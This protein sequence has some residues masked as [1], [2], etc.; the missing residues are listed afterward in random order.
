MSLHFSGAAADE[1]M[2]ADMST[3]AQFDDACFKDLMRVVFSFLTAPKFVRICTHAVALELVEMR[4]VFVILL[5]LLFLSNLVHRIQG[6]RFLTQ[7]SEFATQY[8]IPASTAN[9]VAQS[10][11]LLFKGVQNVSLTPELLLEDLTALG[12]IFF[13]FASTPQVTL[14][15]GDFSVV[16]DVHILVLSQ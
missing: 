9:S 13:S 3:C 4:L 15:R 2:S 16:N 7:L 5:A 6:D 10:W 12:T 8:S 11:L 1:T 14:E